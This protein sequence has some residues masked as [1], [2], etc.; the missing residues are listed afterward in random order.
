M[1]L[2][3]DKLQKDI[4]KIEKQIQI[5]E[6]ANAPVV[7]I[8]SYIID[9]EYYVFYTNEKNFNILKKEKPCK[10]IKLS[11]AGGYKVI[12]DNLGVLVLK[13][14]NSGEVEEILVKQKL[15]KDK[16]LIIIE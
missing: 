13:A 16:S 2:S 6:I 10:I 3:I 4:K 7:I 15:N 5:K 12:R 8:C 14:N 9:N 11:P 1:R